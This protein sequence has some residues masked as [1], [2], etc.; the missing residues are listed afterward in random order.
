[1]LAEELH[2]VGCAIALR[3]IQ[4]IEEENLVAEA[5][6]KGAYLLDALRARLGT[7]PHVG[8]IR[9]SGLMCAVEFVKDRSTKAE[10]LPEE[11]VGARIHAEAQAR[12]L[13][14]RIRGDVFVLALPF[15]TPDSVL[16]RIGETLASST[17]AV[18]G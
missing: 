15:I 14:S 3:T 11:R 7:H 18:L 4:I 17:K 16:D 10:F 9:G 5:S 2:P 1:V 6:R 8:E 13:F 12:G